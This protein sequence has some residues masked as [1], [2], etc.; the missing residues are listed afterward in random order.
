M[1]ALVR[2]SNALPALHRALRPCE[3][4]GPRIDLP[5]AGCRFMHALALTEPFIQGT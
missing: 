5:I 4:D 1:L 3:E 2:Q